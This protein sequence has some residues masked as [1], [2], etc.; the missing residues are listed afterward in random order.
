M[1]KIVVTSGKGGVG[2]T[3]LCARLGSC[4]AAGGNRVVLVDGDVGLNNLDVVMGVENKIVYDMADLAM[5]RCRLKQAL[6]QDMFEATLYI[7]PSSKTSVSEMTSQNFRMLIE[8]LSGYFDYI[9]ID[10]PAGIDSGFHRAVSAADEAIVVTTP[11]ISA[12]RDA[13]K[14]LSLLSTYALKETMLVVNRV[15]G[16]LVVCGDMM[17][18]GDIA[19]LLRTTPVGVIPEDDS[20]IMQSQLGRL[21]RNTGFA[22]AAFAMLA[23]NIENGENELYDCTLP[24]KGAIGKL[25]LML[26]NKL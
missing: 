19:R 9:L 25:K 10:C 7:L 4:L 26:R 22:G 11:H 1:R 24:Y 14:V 13:D 15:R 12:V 20:I 6:V 23:N 17:S 3:T 8:R 2:K 21:T 5:G 16:D 18:E